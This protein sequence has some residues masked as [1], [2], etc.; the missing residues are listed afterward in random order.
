[1]P[2]GPGAVALSCQCPE[3]QA[4]LDFDTFRRCPGA[5]RFDLSHDV[6]NTLDIHLL[7][8]LDQVAVRA[9][10]QAAKHFDHIQ[11]GAQH[12]VNLVHYQAD[13]ATQDGYALEHLFQRQC[14]RK[15]TMS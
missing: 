1:M 3:E 7:P 13:D 15:L 12:V 4:F 8:D 11:P 10:H 2:Q 14:S 9:L 6:V 5:H